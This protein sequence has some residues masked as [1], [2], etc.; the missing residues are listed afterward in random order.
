[1]VDSKTL[2]A[3]RLNGSKAGGE[4]ALAEL[5][6]AD[7]ELEALGAFFRAAKWET[8]FGSIE[9]DA[10]HVVHIDLGPSGH[11]S[12]AP[13]LAGPLKALPRLRSLRVHS[14]IGRGAVVEEGFFDIPTLEK[15]ELAYVM[16]GFVPKELGGLRDLTELSIT[17]CKIKQIDADSRFPPKLVKLDLGHNALTSIPDVLFDIATLEELSL[18]GNKLTSA[19]GRWSKLTRLRALTLAD[20]KLKAL[21]SDLVAPGAAP[22]LEHLDA[23]YNPIKKLPA[24][25]ANLEKLATLDVG[26]TAL[27]AGERERV[28]HGVKALGIPSAD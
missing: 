3:K 20:N 22:R 11:S 17:G 2:V 7:G 24:T 6:L 21:P 4:A 10:G 1:M 26:S 15:L 16:K 14:Y 27:P 25:L 12:S 8:D 9:V 13:P 28:P 23:S 5:G 18:Q 19:E